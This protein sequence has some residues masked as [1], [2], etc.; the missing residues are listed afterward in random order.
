M[1]PD[2]DRRLELVCNTC[3]LEIQMDKSSSIKFFFIPFTTKVCQGTK[4]QSN[5]VIAAYMTTPI[6]SSVASL[7][8]NIFRSDSV[9][10]PVL[11]VC[12]VVG[13]RM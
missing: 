7:I 11:N 12:I 13:V 2:K 1:Q 3:A 5:C 9:K 10:F 6:Q 4:S 8:A